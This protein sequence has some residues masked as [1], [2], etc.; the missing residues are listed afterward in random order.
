[1][2]TVFTRLA[3]QLRNHLLN[4]ETNRKNVENRLS[5]IEE[6]FD[7]MKNEVQK[8]IEEFYTDL[9]DRLKDEKEYVETVVFKKNNDLS[10]RV[11]KLE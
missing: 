8:E 11:N 5:N 7:K 1:M 6:D 4:T 2:K 10:M 9:E 3:E